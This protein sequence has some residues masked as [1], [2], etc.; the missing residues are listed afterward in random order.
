LLNF[1]AFKVC[2]VCI[3]MAKGTL[4][5]REALRNYGELALQMNKKH[6]EEV[7]RKIQRK[8]VKELQEQEDVQE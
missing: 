6:A 1:L 7:L 2:L 8:M 5:S 3:E 4:T